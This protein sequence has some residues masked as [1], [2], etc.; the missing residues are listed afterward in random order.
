MLTIFELYA[1][2]LW[3]E[4][5]PAKIASRIITGA[6]MPLRM[7]W[8]DV[9]GPRMVAKKS[10][11]LEMRNQNLASRTCQYLSRCYWSHF[12]L[13]LSSCPYVSLLCCS[14]A[15]K[16]MLLKLIRN[17]FCNQKEKIILLTPPNYY[18]GTLFFSFTGC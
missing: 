9:T 1:R 5:R 7:F 6:I 14:R 13:N 10:N 12:S 16:N 2:R 18:A 15:V 3:S 4:K 8:K 17:F 11:I